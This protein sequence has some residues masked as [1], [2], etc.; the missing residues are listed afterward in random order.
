MLYIHPGPR[1]VK[2]MAVSRNGG[3]VLVA[4]FGKAKWQQPISR[5]TLFGEAPMSERNRR[6]WW[7]GMEGV[8]SQGRLGDSLLAKGLVCASSFAHRVST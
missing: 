1:T 7:Q 5:G 4:V 8:G 2:T 3:P 6:G